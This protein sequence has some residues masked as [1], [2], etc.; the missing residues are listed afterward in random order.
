M[1]RRATTTTTTK[2]SGMYAVHALRTF[3]YDGGETHQ[4]LE[5][6]NAFESEDEANAYIGELMTKSY[7]QDAGEIGRPIYSVKSE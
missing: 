6:I 5:R 4:A 3:V 2:K 7:Q 1:T